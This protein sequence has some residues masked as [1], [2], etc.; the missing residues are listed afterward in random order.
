MKIYFKDILKKSDKIFLIIFLITLCNYK[1]AAQC[2]PNIDFESGTFNGWQCWTGNVAIVNGKNLITWGASSPGM[3]V[4]NR[5]TMLSSNPGNNNGTDT[6]GLFP[7]NCPNG[8]GHSIKLGNTSVLNEAEGVSYTFTIPPG[9][10]KFT[11]IYNYAVVFEEPNHNPEE[12]PRLK[13]SIENLTDGKEIGCSSF[14]FIPSHDLPGFFVSKNKSETGTDVWCKDWAANSINLNGNA[15]KTIRIFFTSAD[16]T[17]GAHFGYSYIDLNTE[18]DG[19][20]PGSTFCAGDTAVSIVAPFGYKDYA[21]YNKDFSRLLGNQQIV[22]ISPPP[23]SGN[24]IKVI[25]TPYS[26]YGC[27]DTLN[28][29]LSDTLKITAHAGPDTLVCNQVPVQLGVTAS[30]QLKYRWA[31]AAGLDNPDISNPLAIPYFNTAYVVTVTS[32][33]GGCKTT[34]TVN[35]KLKI[36]DSTIRLTGNTDYCIGLGPF[37]VLS[38]NHTDSI[39]WFKNS[40]VIPGATQKLYT[41]NTSGEYFAKLFINTCPLPIE[42]RRIKMIVDSSRLGITYPVKNAVFNFPEPLQARNFGGSVLWS[43]PLSLDNPKS[44]SPIFK[45][46]TQQLYTIQI[47]T[48]TGCITVDTQLVKAN[49]KIAIYMPAAFTPNGNGT[50]EMLRPFLFGFIK[51]NYFRIYNRWGKLLFS[52]NSDL[53][54]WDGKIE[55]APTGIQTVVWMIEAIDVDGKVHNQQGTTV[56]YR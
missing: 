4:I 45:G 31:P 11:L 12:Q 15:G 42:T 1:L 23:V 35:V 27:I 44:Y 49:K 43:P 47:T 3:P 39:Q 34:D 14:S 25:V 5:H 10:N 33:G 32:W 29:V 7:K 52:T 30:S 20:F 26:G 6:F 2:P 28:T 13:I 19:S 38:V 40:T 41:A 56:L 55:N 37:P 21:W 54:G 51:V 50:N 48:A 9:Q 18:C 17:F 22:T 16:C 53:P 8:S 24:L 46:I 36:S